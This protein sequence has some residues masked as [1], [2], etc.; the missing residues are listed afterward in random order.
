M[1]IGKYK[2][3]RS[4]AYRDRVKPTPEQCSNLRRLLERL[5][6]APEKG[7]YVQATG[8]FKTR[9]EF[10]GQDTDAFCVLGAIENEIA[11]AKGVA[12]TE[13]DRDRVAPITEFFGIPSA[14]QDDL[15]HLNDNKGQTLAQIADYIETA[16]ECCD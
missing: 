13:I 1:T 16:V 2:S 8:V 11:L 6:L 4:D 12:W 7:G 3:A 9:R 10:N 15:M 5:R 14:L